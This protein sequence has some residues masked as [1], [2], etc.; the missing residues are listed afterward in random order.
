MPMIWNKIFETAPEQK[1][2]KELY[3]EYAGNKFQMTRDGIL[4]KYEEFE[5]SIELE[6]KWL[7][8]M[9]NN[10]F[11]QLDINSHD[12]FFPLWYI[13]ETNSDLKSL[14][15]LL[16]FT[17]KNLVKAKK[18]YTTI[19]IGQI[20]L[21]LLLSISESS[22]ETQRDFKIKCINTISLLVKK[23]ET[24]DLPN[25]FKIP[26]FNEHSENLSQHQYLLKKISRLKREIVL[27]KVL[28]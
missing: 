9:L 11:K 25:N 3:F 7:D 4:K 24:I 14:N 18:P 22:K 2:A 23:S 12:S 8:E 19:R 28:E 17:E 27:M 26:D 6:K 10:Q 15:K 1:R 5:I 21:K 13:I 16:E 20:I